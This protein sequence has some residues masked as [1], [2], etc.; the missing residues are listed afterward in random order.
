MWFLFSLDDGKQSLVFSFDY[1]GFD[2]AFNLS[3]DLDP[4]ISDLGEMQYVIIRIDLE[5]GLTV[6]Q[7]IM[8]AISIEANM[9]DL[10][11]VLLWR[12]ESFDVE[13]E[14]AIH[15]LEDFGILT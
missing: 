11:T 7:G 5:S 14:S 9:T 8:P 10:S 2:D 1:D 4:N 6:I 3:I 13:P 15:H 12:K